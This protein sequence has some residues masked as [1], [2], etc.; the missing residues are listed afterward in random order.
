MRDYG[1]LTYSPWI[2]PSIRGEAWMA[3]GK[4]GEGGEG[5]IDVDRV[6]SLVS[7]SSNS[8]VCCLVTFGH[9]TIG[10]TTV[11]SPEPSNHAEKRARQ[12]W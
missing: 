4:R 6:P 8:A 7:G 2:E 1:A 3:R 11:A 5:E 12:A 10:K 9:D